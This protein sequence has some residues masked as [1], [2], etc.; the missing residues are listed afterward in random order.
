M[1]NI[2]FTEAFYLIQIYRPLIIAS[3]NTCMAGE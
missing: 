1:I 2:G 3:P